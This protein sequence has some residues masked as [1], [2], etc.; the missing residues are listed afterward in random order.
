MTQL[1]PSPAP[2]S[3]PGGSEEKQAAEPAAWFRPTVWFL[4][5]LVVVG[6]LI[7]WCWQLRGDGAAARMDLLHRGWLSL[8]AVCVG[9]WLL[10]ATT[11][12]T[13][14]RLSSR[15]SKR[16]LLVLCVLV[17][18][19]AVIWLRPMLSAEVLRYRFDGRVWLL[20]LSPYRVSPDDAASLSANVQDA[21]LRPDALDR[22]APHQQRT[23]LNLPVS[24]AGFLATRTLEYLSRAE[25]VEESAAAQTQATSTDWRAELLSLAWWRQMLFWRCLLAGAYLLAV[26]ELIAWLRYR[27]LS[28]WWAVVFAWQPLVVM[29]MLGAGHQDLIG[30]LFLIAGLRR[31]DSGNVRRAAM[32]LAA[33]VAVKP[34]ALLVLPFVI[35]RAWRDDGTEFNPPK[36][37]LAPPASG[38]AARRL[39]VWFVATTALLMMPLYNADAL[40]ETWRA[41]TGYFA[42]AGHDAGLSRV[43]EAVFGGADAS[44]ARLARV[45]LAAWTI[46]ALAVLV[47]GLIAWQRRVG[48][49]GALYAMIMAG[50]VLSPTFGPWLLAWPL[51]MVPLLRGRAGPAVLVWAGTAVLHY[52][53]ETLT[54]AAAPPSAL[55]W[56]MVPVLAVGLVEGLL[57][58]RRM[59]RLR[60]AGAGYG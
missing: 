6:G 27:E 21:E 22:A 47:V 57:V 38:A 35:R 17:A 59:Q 53:R 40:A 60:G 37:S 51:A 31:A 11:P 13:A 30:V 43:L 36:R 23:T 50:L 1:P 14:L 26:A 42:A 4:L 41:V 45:R 58:S 25:S 2:P 12:R 28:P 16:L 34:L 29:E 46:C 7:G 24:Q 48:P 18:A 52:T 15:L 44:E 3:L 9:I 19:A 55:A 20:G 54:G 49:A 5:V 39:V 10:L 32:C 33:S 56:Q 8:A